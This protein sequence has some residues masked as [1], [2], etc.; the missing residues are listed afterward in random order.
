MD[1]ST[2]GRSRRLTAG[3]R[4]AELTGKAL[5]DDEAFWGHDTWQDDEGGSENESFHS[6]DD[7]SDVKKDVFDSD[8]DESESD[9]DE[10]DQKAG[11]LAERELQREERQQKQAA[12]SSKAYTSKAIKASKPLYGRA[13]RV[14]RIM[15]DGMNAGIVLNV[16]GVATLPRAAPKAAPA[17]STGQPKPKVHPSFIHRR[18]T[19]GSATRSVRART[20]DDTQVSTTAAKLSS[21]SSSSRKRPRQRKFTQEELLLEAVNETEPENSRW[22]LARK[23]ILDQSEQSE[24]DLAAT[25]S[26]TKKVIERFVTRRGY[27]T[28]IHF[29]EMD[30]MPSI[31]ATRKGPASQLPPESQRICAIT[32]KPARYR[33]PI[34]GLGYYDIAAFKEI[35]KRLEA[36]K[37][38]RNEILKLPPP[39]DPVTTIASSAPADATADGGAAPVLPNAPI[40]GD[41]ELS[42]Q[43]ETQFAV[44]QPAKR[45]RGRPR[46]I[47]LPEEDIISASTLVAQTTISAVNQGSS[48]TPATK[49]P[50][51]R[52]RKPKAKS[53]STTGSPS[54]DKAV[55]SHPK[56]AALKGVLNGG[57]HVGEQNTT[58]T[59]VANPVLSGAPQSPPG[60]PG[61]ASRRMSPRRRKASTRV[62][63]SLESDSTPASL[64]QTALPSIVDCVALHVLDPSADTT[65]RKA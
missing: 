37:I 32:S 13:G 57:N 55:S 18:E 54:P 38:P 36:G 19:R 46:K 3:K 42:E 11:E 15:G 49:V 6:S 1:R 58:R 50:A 9:H 40:T 62:R 23:R 14:K 20:R 16:P 7:D 8:F 30:H 22:L 39:S 31:L 45:K 25:N 2:G 4:M 41:G 52:G 35:R 34:T 21:S 26:S 17:A 43:V 53:V 5:E 10:E 28:T 48:K 65:A 64:L 27:L 63:E 24:K 61:S 29:P 33:D 56:Q 59:G 12:H 47:R 60:T 44:Q 51:K